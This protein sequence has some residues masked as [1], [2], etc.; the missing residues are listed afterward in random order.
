MFNIPDN[1]K[2]RVVIVGGGFA[3]LQAAERLKKSDFQ[4]VLIDKNNYHQFQPLIYQIATAGL[5]PNSISFPF[6]KLLEKSKDSYF[7][8]AEL[9]AVFPNEKYIQTSIGKL[10]YDY[11]I[12]ANGADTNFFGNQEIANQAMPMKTVAEAM[13]LRNALLSNFERALT[14][15]TENERQE[16]LNVVIVGGGPSGVEI[17]GAIAEMRRYVL[18]HDYPDL[19]ANKMNIYLIDGGT[20]LLRAMSEKASNAA[21]KFLRQF[22]V[23]VMLGERVVDYK[24]RTVYLSSGKTIPSL[25]FIWVGGVQGNPVQGLPAES[26]GPG[27]RILV[28]AFHQVKGVKDIFAIGDVALMDGDLNYKQG[29]PMMAQPAIQQG[30]NLAKN[31]IAKEKGG[32][33][34][35]FAYKDLGSMATIGRNRAVADINALHVTGIVA[36]FLWMVVHLRSILGVHNKL[37]VLMDWTWSYFTYDRSN[38]MIITAKL[39]R[40]LVERR[41]RELRTHWGELTPTADKVADEDHVITLDAAEEEIVSGINKEIDSE[42]SAAAKAKADGSKKA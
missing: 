31:L 39:P 16:L 40:V 32:D 1:G 30:Y 18:P 27:R 5:N 2:K 42:K 34:K 38:R 11:L 13:G 22:N 4:V 3:G 17:A 35:P 29:H 12:L 25:T 10:T 36:W 28:D 21:L 8:L 33:L 7:R 14:C 6:R 24:D 20:K 9:R 23:E 41:M 19:D 26:T 37:A 15:S